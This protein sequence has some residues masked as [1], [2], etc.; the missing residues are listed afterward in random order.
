MT[1]N[2]GGYYANAR[3]YHKLAPYEST[4]V[5]KGACVKTWDMT[6]TQGYHSFYGSTTI[7]DVDLCKTK[8]ETACTASG[9]GCTWVSLKACTADQYATTTACDQSQV[10]TTNGK[11]TKFFFYD[12]ASQQ[13]IDNT[14]ADTCSRHTLTN[15]MCG[16][17]R[18]IYT[19]MLLNMN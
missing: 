9:S 15:L 17:G 7:G 10:H 18:S 14:N 6:D 4:D 11:K 1:A 19:T 8:A 3:P 2:M 5:T 12:V 16:D 13:Q